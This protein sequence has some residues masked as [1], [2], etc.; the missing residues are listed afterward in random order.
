MNREYVV[1]EKMSSDWRNSKAY[2]LV[3]PMVPNALRRGVGATRRRFNAAFAAERTIDFERFKMRVNNREHGGLAHE[4]MYWHELGN[5]LSRELVERLK[6]AY[7]VDVGANY[8]FAS[9]L[10]H[11][12]CPTSRLLAIEPNPG[13]LPYIRGNLTAAGCTNFEV[14]HAVCG[15]SADQNI[16]FAL[17]ATYSQDSRVNGPSSWKTVQVATVTLDQLLMDAAPDAPV[18]IK[19]DTQGYEDN[20]LRGGQRYLSSSSNWMMRMEYGPLWLKSQGTDPLT[21]LGKLV[22]QFVV[23]ELPARVRFQGDGLDDLLRHPLKSEDCAKFE[24]FIRGLG[25][26]NGG[27]CDL[28]VLPKTS[29][30]LR[31]T[32]RTA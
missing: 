25:K 2:S 5:P 4:T 11:A 29:P 15:A 32:Q 8:G 16:S 24:P 1:K 22:D 13:L 30:F 9:L 28:L 31:D 3:K 27:Y 19:V 26:D 14:F 21:L 12:I 20:V 7:F 23:V 6:P 17:N 10:H 18:F